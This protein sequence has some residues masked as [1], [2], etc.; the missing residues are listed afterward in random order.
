V[1]SCSLSSLFLTSMPPA[2][3]SLFPLLLSIPTTSSLFM[4]L[5]LFYFYSDLLFPSFDI[6]LSF[7][8][9]SANMGP[10]TT[11]NHGFLWSRWRCS[12]R[13]PSRPPRPGEELAGHH[14]QSQARVAM[15]PGGRVPQVVCPSFLVTSLLPS[16]RP[17]RKVG[18]EAGTSTTRS[19]PPEPTLRHSGLEIVRSWPKPE[20]PAST[21]PNSS[22][23]SPPS[24]R[25]LSPKKL[26]Q[27]K[28][29]QSDESQNEC[30]FTP[31]V[32]SIALI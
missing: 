23:V 32:S 26:R 2:M 20:L 1:L 29:D 7:R 21:Q 12:F 3:Y 15:Y 10:A 17:F 18:L 28:D 13:G 16:L 8:T 4:L 6:F 30:C 25:S 24:T 27:M 31:Q 5:V 9:A 14:G 11:Y 19:P 22:A